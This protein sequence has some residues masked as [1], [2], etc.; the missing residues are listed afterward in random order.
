M[1]DYARNL[2]EFEAR[3]ASEEDCRQY[4]FR[5]RWPD[6]FRCQASPRNQ[7]SESPA[8]HLTMFWD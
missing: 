1:E 4:L 6:G 5:L 8:R 3:F 7:G 2:I